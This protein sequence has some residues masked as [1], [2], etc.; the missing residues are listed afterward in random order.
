MTTAG[1]PRRFRCRYAGGRDALLADRKQFKALIDR[2]RSARPFHALP[3]SPAAAERRAHDRAELPAAAG[4]PRTRRSRGN[5][6]RGS[7]RRSTIRSSTTSRSAARKRVGAEDA[8]VAIARPSVFSRTRRAATRRSAGRG[9]RSR[10]GGAD[11]AGRLDGQ[12]VHHAMHCW[13]LRKERS[14]LSLIWAGA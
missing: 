10:A 12:G 9:T 13:S 4:R 8:L 7:A 1:D 2:A 5:C 14:Y 11:P 3:S 6:A